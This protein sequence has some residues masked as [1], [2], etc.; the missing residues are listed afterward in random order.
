MELRA[1]I[2]VGIVSA[3]QVGKALIVVKHVLLATMAHIV[4]I[5]A[6]V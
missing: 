3:L 1:C 2:R 5:N 6:L 4:L